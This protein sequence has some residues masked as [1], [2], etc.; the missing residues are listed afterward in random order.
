MS[1]DPDLR[2]FAATFH[3]FLEFVSNHAPP[4]PKSPIAGWI[5]E[6]FG[7]DTAP[8]IVERFPVYQHAD[9]QRALDA[10]LKEPG[11][12]HT[13]DGV[14][15]TLFS[16]TTSL[17]TIGGAEPGPVEYATI[18]LGDGERI[19]CVERGLYRVRDKQKQPY[20]L[21]VSSRGN[22]QKELKLEVMAKTR[23]DGERLLATLRDRIRKSSVY[24]GKILSLSQVG[25]GDLAVT[26]HKSRPVCDADIV[27][28][29]KLLRRIERHTVGFSA[30]AE[31][32]G[33]AGQHMK[34]GLLLHGRPG[35]GKTLTAMYLAARMQNRTVLLLTG[36]GIG[37]IEA[38]CKMARALQPA[39]VVIEDVDLIAEE[40]TR[41]N[42]ANTTLLF[43]LLNQ[44][45]GVGEDADVL[46]LLTTNRPDILEPALAAR[47]GRVDQ[48]IELPLPDDACRMRLLE[49][50]SADLKWRA[51]LEGLVDRT[52]GASA[53][54]MR[55]LVRRSALIAADADSPAV[56]QEHV[57]TALEELIVSG[58]ELTRSLLGAVEMT[59]TG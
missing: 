7:T 29:E 30:K 41:V 36:G 42:N 32:L 35:T 9:L 26:I 23:E 8:V 3:K 1:E 45:D 15:A 50:Y 25:S 21:L 57:E 11:R 10:W 39:T 19:T 2:A 12:S 16:D 33:A 44:M 38:A 43:E 24:R 37:L 13:L 34:R 5:E 31:K 58:G 17:S 46:F 47:P 55:E 6:L 4:A 51:D 59:N 20:A 52:A 27:L 56:E 40:R 14:K 54:F 48:A 18:D 22:W 28:P 53:A 49:L